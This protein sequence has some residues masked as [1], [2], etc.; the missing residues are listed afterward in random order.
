MYFGTTKTFYAADCF[1]WTDHGHHLDGS[2]R[3]TGSRPT[4]LLHVHFH[5]MPFER[6]VRSVPQ[7]WIGTVDITD[8]AQL[9]GYDGASAHLARY[10]LM[11]AA[12]YYGQFN[13]KA[14]VH[15]PQ[16]RRWLHQLGAPLKIP[17]D[18]TEMRMLDPG[19]SSQ[20]AFFVPAPVHNAQY[21]AANPDVAAAGMDG[22]EHFLSYGFRE[23]R[24]L[25]P[26]TEDAPA[27][28]DPLSPTMS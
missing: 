17:H 6:L 27:P 10:L 28:Y 3:A 20:T 16:L 25:A 1:S 21:F 22:F 2:H 9:A 15:F 8:P 14:L 11:N 18:D 26:P 19:E 12:E 23:G 13:T 24:P 7:R 5:Y 4:A